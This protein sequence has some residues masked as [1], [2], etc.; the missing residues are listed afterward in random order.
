MIALIPARGGSKGLPGKNTRMFLDIPL[1]AH[2]IK[3]SKASKNVSQVI[4]STDDPEIYRVGLE[5]GALDTFLRPEELARDD[6][7]AIDNYLYTLPRLQQ[8]F[9]LDVENFIVLQPTS[10]LRTTEDINS[11]IE[12]FHRKSA[13]SVVSYTEEFHPVIWHKYINDEG[14]FENIFPDSIENRQ[15]NRKSYYP[16]GA[17][18]VFRYELI[19]QR[20]YYSDRSFAYLMP[21]QRSV[22][23]DTLSDFEYAEFLAK[24]TK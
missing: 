14:K 9:G 23:I 7:K 22:D 12:L 8:E 19:T 16:N 2:T 3:S 13:D 11:A 1:I 15:Q 24:N 21:R 5:Y 20:K 17:I 4:V 18:Y 6:S 10:P